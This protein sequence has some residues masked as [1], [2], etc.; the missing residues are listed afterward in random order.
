MGLESERVGFL[1]DALYEEVVKWLPIVSVEALI[2]IDDALLFLKRNNDPV[3]GKWWFPGGRIRRGEAL[4]EALQREIK[5]E[6]GLSLIEHKL[7]GV[8]SRV[9]AQRHDIT[10]AY[11]CK[12]KPGRVALNNEHSEYRLFKKVPA[13]L[14]AYLLETIRD[15]NWKKR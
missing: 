8:Y 10:I 5:E 4:K 6:T 7:I 12:C 3:K 9:F 15:S 13:G 2:V 11:L 14:D 1:P